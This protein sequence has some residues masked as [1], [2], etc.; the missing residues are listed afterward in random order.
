MEKLTQEEL[1]KLRAEKT[2]LDWRVLIKPSEDTPTEWI[3]TLDKY[4]QV[5]ATPDYIVDDDG[6]T[7]LGARPCLRCQD[8]LVPSLIE[9]LL[10]RTGFTWGL[11]H[12]EGYCANCGW[13]ARAH[14]Y[15]KT[16][17]GETIC[18]LQH[19]PLQYHPDGIELRTK[20]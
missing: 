15:V 16:P 17:S 20:T 5:F 7:V 8:P 18:V 14:H 19:L 6:I 12:G 9:Q 11:V 10:K 3:E 13:P 4:F 2:H 1:D